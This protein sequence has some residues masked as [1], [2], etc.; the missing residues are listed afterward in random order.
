MI[1]RTK[2]RVSKKNYSRRSTTS[3][4]TRKP[5]TK[6]AEKATTAQHTHYQQARK[7]V[8]TA[9]FADDNTRTTALAGQGSDVSILSPEVFQ[10]PQNHIESLP[11]A[12]LTTHINSLPLMKAHKLY[13]AVGELIQ[14]SSLI[15]DMLLIS[16]S[17]TSA[18]L[19]VIDQCS[20][21]S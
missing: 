20:I 18:G 19:S 8:F 3:L 2:I 17:G 21:S 11:G 15:F 7:R 4:R 1:A 5:V 16:S 9:F 12:L 14:R 13:Y 6:S 10:K